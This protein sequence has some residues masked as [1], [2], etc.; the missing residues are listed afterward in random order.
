MSYA[1]DGGLSECYLNHPRIYFNEQSIKTSRSICINTTGQTSG[2]IPLHISNHIRSVYPNH[3]I[4]QVGYKTDIDANAD[5]DRRWRDDMAK[6]AKIMSECEI[7]IGI[8]S[9]CYW[10]SKCFK[11]ARKIILVNN[12]EKECENFLPRGISAS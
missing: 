8:D 12:T 6:S 3:Y 5:F 10:L 9:F 1:I 7:F 4:F 2:S 11:I